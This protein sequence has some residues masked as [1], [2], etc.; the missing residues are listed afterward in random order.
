MPW[1]RTWGSSVPNAYCLSDTSD[2]VAVRCK[3]SDDPWKQAG[4]AALGLLHG[5]G[6]LTHMAMA[7]QEQSFD[8]KFESSNKA[9]LISCQKGLPLRVVRSHKVASS[10]SWGIC[11]DVCVTCWDGMA[12]SVTLL[13]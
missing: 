12:C 10:C 8:Q 9:L 11:P 3:T 13:I 6:R 5:V 1:L 7:V 4:L 2:L